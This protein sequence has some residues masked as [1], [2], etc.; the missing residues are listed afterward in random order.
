MVHMLH[1][2]RTLIRPRLPCSILSHHMQAD[3]S[4]WEPLM[5]SASRCKSVDPLAE[6]HVPT[7]STAAR[8]SLSGVTFACSAG[9][10]LL[11]QKKMQ[12]FTPQNR[13]CGFTGTGSWCWRAGVSSFVE[14]LPRAW[15]PWPQREWSNQGLLPD[16]NA[17]SLAGLPLIGAI[18]TSRHCLSTHS[19]FPN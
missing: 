17:D 10:A 18:I 7:P 6:P 19:F 12:D 15:L 11:S 4:C 8:P 3:L 1:T 14:L 16:C 9:Q 5:P 2:R 13:M